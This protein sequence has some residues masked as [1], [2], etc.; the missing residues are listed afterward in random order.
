M[1]AYDIEHEKDVM[2]DCVMGKVCMDSKDERI[3]SVEFE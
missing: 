3:V 1:I 2:V